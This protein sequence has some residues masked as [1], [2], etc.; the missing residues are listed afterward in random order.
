MWGPAS[1]RRGR[2]RG[3]ACSLLL[4]AS[5]PRGGAVRRGGFGEDR[6]REARQALESAAADDPN[7]VVREAAENSL[8]KAKEGDGNAGH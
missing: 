7:Q 2:L 3:E 6:G 1:G 8:K 5:G 4:E